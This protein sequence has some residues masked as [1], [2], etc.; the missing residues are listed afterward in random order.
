MKITEK[1]PAPATCLEP[2][3][4]CQNVAS[5]IFLGISLEGFHLK[6]LNWFYVFLFIAYSLF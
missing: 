6:W 3:A 1:V 4:H 5:L 2:L